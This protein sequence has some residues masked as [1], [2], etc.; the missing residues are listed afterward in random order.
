MQAAQDFG[1]T[2]TDAERSVDVVMRELQAQMERQ[3]ISQ[4]KLTSWLRKLTS[5]TQR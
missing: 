1:C 3:A 4:D 2:T 5:S